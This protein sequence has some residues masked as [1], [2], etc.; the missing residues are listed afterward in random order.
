MPKHE[1]KK[2]DNKKLQKMVIN[3]IKNRIEICDDPIE[4][5][6]AFIAQNFEP[7]EINKRMYHK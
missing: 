4:S 7:N 1:Y 3:E 2:F 5:I 6:V